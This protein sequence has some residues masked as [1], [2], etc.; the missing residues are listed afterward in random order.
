MK[1][2]RIRVKVEFEEIDAETDK[3]SHAR[4]VEDGCFEIEMDDSLALDIDACEQ[5]LL[6]ANFPALRDA[7]RV[8][9][10][11]ESKKKS[12]QRKLDEA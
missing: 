2:R 5:S 1:R 6:A 3:Q 7:L 8:H 4:K 10:E 9:L 11:N 12:A